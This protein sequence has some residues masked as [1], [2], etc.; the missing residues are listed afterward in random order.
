ME[1]QGKIANIEINHLLQQV[2]RY[3]ISNNQSKKIG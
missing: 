1:A 2:R 3:P